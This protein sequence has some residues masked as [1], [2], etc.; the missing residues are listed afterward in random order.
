MIAIGGTNM[1]K[2]ISAFMSITACTVPFVLVDIGP[3]YG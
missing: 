1:K 2:I 3:F